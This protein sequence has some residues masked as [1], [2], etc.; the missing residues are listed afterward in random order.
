MFFFSLRVCV[1]LKQCLS[2]IIPKNNHRRAQ[3][4]REIYYHDQCTF[5]FFFLLKQKKQSNINRYFCFFTYTNQSYSCTPL[6]TYVP[7]FCLSVLVLFF[8]LS[9]I[10]SSHIYY[11]SVFFLSARTLDIF[12][13]NRGSNSTTHIHLKSVFVLEMSLF[14]FVHSSSC[15]V[16]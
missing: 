5:S 6:Y 8:L 2:R 16:F 14:S 15:F 4:K 13:E 12:V 3:N 9:N 11:K 10:Y 1:F 7:F